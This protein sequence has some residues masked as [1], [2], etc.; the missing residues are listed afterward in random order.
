MLC[1]ICVK[2]TINGSLREVVLSFA[3]KERTKENC[4]C[5]DAAD[6]RT[7]GLHAPKTPKEGSRKSRRLNGRSITVRS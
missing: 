5:F 1:K 3:N 6:P 2:R 4:R 7:L